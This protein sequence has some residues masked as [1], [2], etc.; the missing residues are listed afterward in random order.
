MNRWFWRSSMRNDTAAS[1]PRRHPA[2]SRYRVRNLSGGLMDSPRSPITDQRAARPLQAKPGAHSGPAVTPPREGGT[3]RAVA[4]VPEKGPI[5]MVNIADCID[6]AVQGGE[7]DKA[8]GEAAKTV[9]AELMARYAST[10]PEHTARML[11]NK[12]LA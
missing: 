12:D 1:A 2:T 9:H 6:A 7:L 10:M 8:K 4:A 3:Q 11:A 5:K